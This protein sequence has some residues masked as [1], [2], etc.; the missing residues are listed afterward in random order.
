MLRNA[1]LSEEVTVRPDGRI[2]IIVVSDQF[3]CKI[4]SPRLHAAHGGATI[5][6][7]QGGRT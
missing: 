2:A 4:T 5:P 7:N 3:A 6:H 1:A